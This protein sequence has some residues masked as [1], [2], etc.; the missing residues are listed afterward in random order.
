MKYEEQKKEVNPILVRA[1]KKV[2]VI[3]DLILPEE[4]IPTVMRE[5]EIFF[6]SDFF[7]KTKI[8]ERLDQVK[9]SDRDLFV[10]GVMEATEPIFKFVVEHP[11]E[12][13]KMRRLRIF[14]DGGYIKV[15]ELIYYGKTET[16]DIHM[17]IA[18]HEQTSIGKKI[19]LLR[20]GINKLA[21]EVRNDPTVKEVTATSWIVAEAPTLLKQLGFELHGEIS[22]EF[23][24]EHFADETRPVHHASI[25]REVLLEKYPTKWE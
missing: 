15:N 13:E 19:K 11:E 24:Q 7:D 20:E 6:N 17:H 12:Y 18:P 14:N 1:K 3:F 5:L 10:N 23:R 21:E 9:Q 22:E 4:R 25:S 16:G 2:G 8:K